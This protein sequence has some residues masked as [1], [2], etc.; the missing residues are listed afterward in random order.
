MILTK[1][2]MELRF[3]EDVYKDYLLSLKLWLSTA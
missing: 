2:K 1:K 3:R